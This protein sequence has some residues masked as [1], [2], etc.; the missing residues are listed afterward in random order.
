LPGRAGLKHLL[1][2][3]AIGGQGVLRL[4]VWSPLSLYGSGPCR[5][6]APHPHRPGPPARRNRFAE[7]YFDK[8]PARPDGAFRLKTPIPNTQGAAG[9]LDA[10][11]CEDRTRD[12]AG[13]AET[14]SAGTAMASRHR[15]NSAA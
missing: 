1:D 6:P 10:W 12:W 2:R 15:V 13:A 3:V 4:P 7:P 11:Q 9:V 5:L 14:I 8:V